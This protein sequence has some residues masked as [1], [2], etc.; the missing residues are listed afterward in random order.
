MAAGLRLGKPARR[1]RE[2]STRLYVAIFVEAALR[3]DPARTLYF[4]EDYQ[5]ILHRADCG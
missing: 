3:R 2:P 4:I 1:M 5:K